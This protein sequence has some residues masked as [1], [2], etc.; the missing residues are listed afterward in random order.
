MLV[1]SPAFPVLW[2]V[3]SQALTAAPAQPSRH[4]GDGET[5]QAY[6]QFLL[7]GH[8]ESAGDNERAMAAFRE[9]ARLDPASAEIRAEL[10]GF[11]ARQGRL[12]DAS[13]E[14][15][16]ALAIDPANHEANR[17]L[18]SILA[19]I[20][21]PGVGGD[22][23]SRVLDEATLHLER[24][25][26][27]DGTDADPA[28]DLLLARLYLRSGQHQKAIVLLQELLAR[29]LMPEAYLLLAEAWRDAGNPTEAERALEAGAE[30]NPR[31]LVSLAEM[32]EGQ[33]RWTEAATAYERASAITPPSADVKTRWAGA[34]LNV[35][36]EAATARA[37]QMLE[38][39]AAAQ[40]TNDRTL[41]LL[42]QAQ[43]R[44]RDLAAA[45]VTARRVIALDPEGLWGPWALAQVLEDRRDYMG[46]V[47][48]LSAALS[49]SSSRETPP[50]RQVPG[51]LTHLGFAQLQLGQYDDAAA[52][53]A[54]AKQASGGDDT[55][56]VYL[57]Q[58]YVSARRFDEA[59]RALEPLRA[60]NPRDY[61]VA[62][63]QA[64]AL[65]GAGRR[66][67][68][69]T[70]LR[71]LVDA[72]ADQ[73]SVYLSLAD[74]LASDGRL[75][76]AH[77]VLDQAE[78]RF[79]GNVS[80]P[81]QRGALYERAKE[82]G[83]AEEAFRAVIALEP[84]HAQALNY[85]GYMLAERGERLEEAVSLIRR[86]LAID[87]GNG[88]YLDSLG[89]AYFKLRRHEEARKHLAAAAAQL[90]SNSV[91]QDHLGDALAALG[92]HANAIGAWQRALAGD[93]EAIDEAVIDSKIARAR[94]QASR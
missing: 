1:M 26:R 10:A 29:E 18:G 11:F 52:T 40:P 30:A 70:T 34:L 19:S 21:Q 75:A 90:P 69:I 50:S 36:D 74:M 53:F 73:P 41:Y 28:L 67:E 44:M 55:F 93:R 37:R 94:E 65:A 54:R 25:R 15:R 56:D 33:Q 43:R 46:V 20:A 80:V 48:T 14:A 78:G 24:G 8:Y 31:L 13:R 89:W 51:M 82:F 12:D 79:P 2:L 6:Y 32:Y 92:Q 63:L 72:D 81:F 88:S 59:L 47:T 57:A 17:I 84:A 39:L 23:D 60:K 38:Q 77:A 58:A 87:P 91:V 45:E 7:G 61:R 64:R 5:A 62:Q 35:Q 3:L 22:G 9:A 68:A 16:A 42:S 76:D 66:D 49:G 27:G 86:A 83:R 4:T 85:L 71:A